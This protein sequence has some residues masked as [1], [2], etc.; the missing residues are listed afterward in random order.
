MK[1]LLIIFSVLAVMMVIGAGI[2]YAQGPD[3]QRGRGR[4]RGPGDGGHVID[5]IADALE[6]DP[7]DVATQVQDGATLAEIIE[8]NDGDL[9]AIKATL[10]EGATE[11]INQAVEVGRLTQEEADEKLADLETHIDELLSGEFELRGSGR[12]WGPGDGGHVIDTVADALELDPA[13]VITQVQDGATLA[14]IIEANGGDLAAITAELVAAQ[15]EHINQ[16]VEDG[17]LTQEE[18]D[19]KLADLETHIDE[20]LNGEFEARGPG[21]GRRGPRGENAP[22]SAPADDLSTNA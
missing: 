11:R 21:H 13:D 18:A 10:M 4:G 3:G 19:E 9:E 1:R 14:E 20:F 16:A 15:T 7:T 5:T 8:A 12:G 22:D 6:L 17:R 2:I